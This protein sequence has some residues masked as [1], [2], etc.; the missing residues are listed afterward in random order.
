[1]LEDA[2]HKHL[3]VVLVLVDESYIVLREPAAALEVGYFNAGVGLLENIPQ[4]YEVIVGPP[5]Y[6]VQW[7]YFQAVHGVVR[8]KDAMNHLVVV[9]RDSIA[10]NQVVEFLALDGL[11]YSPF[12]ELVL[13][14]ALV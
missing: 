10:L 12:E 5:A 8:Q 2:L 11:V 4:A 1:M 7:L 6:D 9:D 14:V 13:Q 3:Q